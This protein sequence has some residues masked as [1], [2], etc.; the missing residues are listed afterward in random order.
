MAILRD[1]KVYWDAYDLT[2]DLSALTLDY[3]VDTLDD[4]ALGDTFRSNAAGLVTVASQ[5]EGFYRSGTGTFEPALMNNLAIQD[6]P[7]TVTNN[8]TEGTTAWFYKMLEG[9]YHPIKGS[10]GELQT[11][12]AGG[13][14]NSVLV[15]GQSIAV[16]SGII[17]TA[18]G[19]AYQV[20]AVPAGKKLYVALHIL[21]VSGTNPT[22]DLTINSDDASGFP[23]ST[24]RGT[25]SQK[26]GIGSDWMEIAGP[27]TDDWWRARWVVG[28]TGTPTFSF[29]LAAGIR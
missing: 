19:T 12:S 28:G 22:L 27:I 23:S 3:G 9:D 4:T 1:Q 2:G 20:G 14:A 24:T 21:S 16:K 25:F 10:S 18:N 17:A 15:K 6:K 8:G 11:F 26:T 5:I 13:M 7:F 29:I